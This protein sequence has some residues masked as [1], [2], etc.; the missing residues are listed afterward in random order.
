MIY[1][2]VDHCRRSWGNENMNSE[3]QNM[4]KAEQDGNTSLMTF[5]DAVDFS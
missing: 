1:F 3:V 5:W 2:E 4:A